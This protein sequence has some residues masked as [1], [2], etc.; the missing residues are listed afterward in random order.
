M[1]LQGPSFGDVYY[2]EG[3]SLVLGSNPFEADII[4]RDI[5]VEWRH[6][7][8]RRGA[9][10]GY[11][12]EDLGTGAPAVVNEENVEGTRPLRCGDRITVGDSVLEFIER[13]PIKEQF[14]R[15]I[16]RLINHDHLT[17]LLAK[18]RLD[19]RF[20]QSLE[21][22]QEQGEPLGVLMADIDNLK[23]INDSYGHLFGEFA[24]GEIGHIIRDCLGSEDL[25]ATRFGGD[26]YQMVLP[27]LTKKESLTVAE[28]I[29]RHIEAYTFEQNGICA[30]PTLSL[31]VAAYPEDGETRED[32][33]RA[34]DKAL[35]RAKRAGG[36]A[37]CE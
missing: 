9:R 36:N 19:E 17:G 20:G 34:A 14:H 7:R 5:E 23:K 22:C 4:I 33:T 26:E 27:G 2:L 24:V 1:V 3:D 35:Y 10:N 25:Y 15:K 21:I 8:I 31:G 32:L 28:E 6:A 18:N 37:V 29:R 12:L 11:T 30:N 13:D 16:Q